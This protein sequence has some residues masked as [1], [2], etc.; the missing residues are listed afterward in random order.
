[1]H[2]EGRR[3]GKYNPQRGILRSRDIREG[4]GGRGRESERELPDEPV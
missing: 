3:L 2:K 1:M 4:E